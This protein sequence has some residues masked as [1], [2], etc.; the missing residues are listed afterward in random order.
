MATIITAPTNPSY[1]YFY[2][3][4]DVFT[5]LN[6]DAGT[7]SVYLRNASS[8][9]LV[10][11]NT[12]LNKT[13]INTNSG[14]FNIDGTNNVAFNMTS[15]IQL[16]ATAASNFTTSVGA[17]TL[18]ASS[19]TAT[20]VVNISAA[21]TGTNSVLIS[22]TNATSG[23]VHITSAGAAAS[24][25]LIDATNA[26][27][28]VLLQSAGTSATAIQL[29]SSAGGVNVSATALINITTTDGTNGITIGTGTGNVPV[30][31][32][33]STSLTTIQGNLTVKGTTTTVNTVTLNFQN[34]SLILN[35]GNILAGYDAGISIRRY[36]IP[37]GGVTANPAGSV[38]K[39]GGP[40]QE[41]GAFS[42]AGTL[43][44]TL[45][46][47]TF[48][49]TTNNFYKGWWIVV[50]S[51]SGINQVARIKSYVGST[52]TATIYATTDNTTNPSF[53][54]GVSLTVAPA[55]GDTYSLYDS[56]FPS[57]YYNETTG[58][59]HF[60]TTADVEDGVTSVTIQ[61]PQNIQTGAV[62]IQ[63]KTYYNANGSAST[64]TVTFTLINHG[65]VVG[66]L[67]RVVSTSAFTPDPS[68]TTPY[69]VVSVPTANTFTITVAAST[70]TTTASSAQLYFYTTSVLSAN[71]IQS[72]N[73][74]YPI[75]IPGISVY[76]D[77]VIPVTS[78][79]LFNVTLTSNY[80]AYMLLVCDKS[81]TGA[82]SIFAC[83]NNT[84]G[85]TP[86]RLVSAKNSVSGARISALWSATSQIQIYQAPAAASGTGNYTYRC[87]IMS[88]I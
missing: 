64:T 10:S 30:T 27:G 2:G 18:S 87:R 70:T 14:S 3:D 62:S 61:Q 19:A 25:V 12:N 24:S 42:A 20:G 50:T 26:T 22:A 15:A 67:I 80:G 9:F 78:T 58:N 37:Q 60:S 7:G 13:Y 16:N 6:A 5:P 75:S 49:S 74:E 34:N 4:I 68:S 83:C 8:S 84:L 11:G 71:I 39:T 76:Q 35:S 33:T 48:A 55:I 23:Q 44:G 21:G 40:I 31:I 52:L 41:S 66:N 57:T 59:W 38:I 81:G 88:C 45:V 47:S 65:L 63:G 56:G 43:P 73:P 29:N 77:I 86:S 36:Q 54:D 79:S 82:T 1:S 85:M 69:S 28:Q 53:T 17:L 72:F 46:L 32:G 51:G